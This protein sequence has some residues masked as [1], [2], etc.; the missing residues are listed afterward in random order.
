MT[1]LKILVVDDED[2]IRENLVAFL[3]D[4]GYEVISA[5]S[6]EEAL[7][8]LSRE[9]ADIGIVDMRLPGMDGNGFILAAH[10]QFSEMRF[11]IHTGSTDY[12]LP[13]SLQNIGLT[14]SNI[15][16]K[17]IQDMSILLDALQGI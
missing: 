4:E 8:L 15:F 2:M 5:A 1:E 6:A 14:N 12:I 13:Q 3:E 17:P 10:G 11:L 16:K 7:E 9:P